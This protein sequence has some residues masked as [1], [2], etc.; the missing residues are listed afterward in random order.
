M[1][2][3]SIGFFDEKY[4]LSSF[5][6]DVF[7]RTKGIE[8]CFNVRMEYALIDA[9]NKSS[10]DVLFMNLTRR[11]SFN[12]SL[13]KKIKNNFP[14]LKIVGFIYGIE[15]SQQEVF[16]L[17]NEGIAAIITDAHSPQ[18][19]FH[20]MESVVEKGFHINDIVNEA[21]FNYCKRSHL[22]RNSFGPE[23]KFS[24]REIKII[25][26]K[27]VGKTSKEIADQLYVSKKT[28]DGILQDMYSR[29]GCKN[30]NELSRKYDFK[31]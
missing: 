15:L 10:P 14:E 1:Q 19:I 18:D 4:L 20:A 11:I 2:P 17:I 24:E 25:E 21:M 16:R 13:I 23:A 27:K 31:L 9:L 26:E 28:V 6:H 29:F 22:F 30:F 5:I 8:V 12:Y 7:S 3:V